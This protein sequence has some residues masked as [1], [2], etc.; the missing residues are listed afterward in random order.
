MTV[1]DGMTNR[2]VIS[3][4]FLSLSGCASL[5]EA[6]LAAPDELL[7]TALD[8][9]F[10]APAHPRVPAAP[11]DATAELTEMDLVRLTLAQN[12]DLQA[13]RTRLGVAKAQLTSLGI[14]PDPQVSLSP[15]MGSHPSGE[16]GKSRRRMEIQQPPHRAFRPKA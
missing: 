15:V 11:V 14:V 7:P 6:P 5:G 2:L 8:A 4:V 9:Q 3:V 12:P 1:G 13:Q 10:D 16:Q